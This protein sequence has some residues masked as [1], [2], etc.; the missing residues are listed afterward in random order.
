MRLKGVFYERNDPSMSVFKYGRKRHSRDPHNTD[1]VWFSTNSEF[2]ASIVERCNK[3]LKT[4][5]WKYFTQ[6]GYRKWINVLD[7]LVYDYNNTY[8][9]SIKMIPVKGSKIDNEKIVFNN[10]YKDSGGLGQLV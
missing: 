10:L 6:V 5:M 8:H 7:D 3:T 9:T 1:Y 4:K 2:K